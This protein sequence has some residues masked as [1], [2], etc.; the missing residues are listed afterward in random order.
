MHR[1]LALTG[2]ALSMVAGTAVMAAQ[3]SKA[4]GL[5]PWHFQM[6]PREVESFTDYGP[7]KAFS[8]GDLETYAGIFNGRKENVQ[9]FFKD[10]KLVR[11][12]IYLYEGQD[13]KAAAGTWGRTYKTLKE[14]F[15]AIELP[16]I[17]VQPNGSEPVPET[18]AIAAGASVD[19]MGKSQMAPFKQPS[20]VFVFA[21]FWRNKLGGQVS[22]YVVVYYDSPHG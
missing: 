1:V 14:K 5:P 17:V 11:I 22:Y 16:G 4:G 20:D 3:S 7:Y 2:L 8:N 15:G 18:V 21:S 12:G 10:G 6:T 9:F 13:I 19:A